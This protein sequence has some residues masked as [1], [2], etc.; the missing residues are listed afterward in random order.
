VTPGFDTQAA[1]L[2]ELP[3]AP[4]MDPLPA[5]SGDFTTPQQAPEVPAAPGATKADSMQM[6]A[7]LRDQEKPARVPTI[8]VATM[9]PAA[10]LLPVIKP[11]ARASGPVKPY[12]KVAKLPPTGAQNPAATSTAK[13]PK[14]VARKQSILPPFLE[15]L[16]DD[17]GQMT[18]S[19]NGPGKSRFP[20]SGDPDKKGYGSND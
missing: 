8:A 7:D 13:A 17:L 11:S 16:F 14:P 20:G 1:S 10:E 6:S 19:A 15:D 4:L 5:L 3:A 2:A 18:T 9:D 12:E